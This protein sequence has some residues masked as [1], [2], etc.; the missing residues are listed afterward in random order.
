[1]SRLTVWGQR[2]S[3]NVQKVLWSLE[4]LGLDFERI[5]VGAEFGRLR[6]PAYLALNPNGLVPTLEDG[7]TV[8]WESNAIVRYLFAKYGT[9]P[10]YPRDFG[11]RARADG[12][13]DWAT[14]TLWA[15]VRPLLLQ[16]TRTPEPEQNQREIEGAL[17]AANRAI[18]ILD[19]ELELESYVAGAQFSFGDIP[20][21][22]AAQRWF[23][24][25]V[26]RAS[27][28]H[29]DAWY[30]RIQ[31]RPAFQHWVDAPA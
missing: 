5:D 14:T 23:R 20:L 26:A 3:S 10:M 6:D 15:Q 1:M 11:R 9:D 18:A 13:C 12:W 25:P 19:R 16:L 24:L 22:V 7:E 31:A 28:P 29:V 21:G 17:A 4:E 8:L 27:A 2:R 30:A